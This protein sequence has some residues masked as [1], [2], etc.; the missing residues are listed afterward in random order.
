MKAMNFEQMENVN[1]GRR[2]SQGCK[3]ALVGMGAGA[4]SLAFTIATF[5]AGPVSLMA[6]GGLYA[7]MGGVSLGAAMGIANC[8]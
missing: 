3:E 5:P 1:G 8:F 6:L 2:M 7:S 4:I